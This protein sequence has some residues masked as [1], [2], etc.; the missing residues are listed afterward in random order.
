M[1]LGKAEIF[2]TSKKSVTNIPSTFVN[3]CEKCTTPHYIY[4]LVP[5][6]K[7]PSFIKQWTCELLKI[8]GTFLL[9]WFVQIFVQYEQV[10]KPRE[11]PYTN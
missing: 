10:F 9:G 11:E 4:Y 6:F 2:C 8:K 5:N 3:L 1:D 7:T